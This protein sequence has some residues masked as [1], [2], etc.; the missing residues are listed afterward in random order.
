MKKKKDEKRDDGTGIF[1]VKNQDEI[2]NSLK[3]LKSQGYLVT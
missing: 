3:S 2:L 1:T